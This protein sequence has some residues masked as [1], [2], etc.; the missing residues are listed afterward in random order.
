MMP[1][2]LSLPTPEDNL[3]HHIRA[4]PGLRSELIAVAQLRAPREERLVF[5]KALLLGAAIQQQLPLAQLPLH[6]LALASLRYETAAERA[7]LGWDKTALTDALKLERQQL[8]ALQSNRTFLNAAH[9][10]FLTLADLPEQQQRHALN[11]ILQGF[12]LADGYSRNIWIY[13]EIGGLGFLVQHGVRSE[14]TFTPGG[15][16]VTA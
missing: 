1:L 3:K 12:V 14:P 16:R 7:D 4:T 15:E 6:D 11:F 8:R 9:Q 2:P 13:S 5:L 10:L